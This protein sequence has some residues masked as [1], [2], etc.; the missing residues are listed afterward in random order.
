MQFDS[1]FS[2]NS[3]IW[4]TSL[5]D[6]ELGPTRRMVEDM[7]SLKAEIS[8]GFQHIQVNSAIHLKDV[9]KELALHASEHG[10]RPLLH[11]DMHGSKEKGLYISQ[12]SE[13]IAWHELYTNLQV[14][15]KAS[16]NNLVVIGAAC[17]GLKAIMPIKLD[18]PAPFFVLLAPEEEVCVG[19]LEDNAVRFYRAL[20]ES[21]SLDT[22]YSRNL[23]DEF[24]YF[25]CEKMLFIVVAKYIR[26][27][28][29]G[30]SAQ[31]R[32]EQLLTDVFSQGMDKTEANLKLVREKIKE[33]L[34]P[35]QSL[36][37]KYAETF[38]IGRTCSFNMQQLLEFLDGDT[39]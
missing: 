5:P 36:L 21:G 8:I 2:C 20:F 39:P 30:K 1:S 6:S 13:Y 29:R 33:G 37:D 4:V 23:S 18:K 11:F 34:K 9:L 14:L 16:G 15:N 32:R 7:E 22:A 12:S 26:A 24:K 27:G 28:C 35:E 17:F 25:H 38:L 10:M 31:E 3:V 19:F